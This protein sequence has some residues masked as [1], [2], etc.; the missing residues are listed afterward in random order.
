MAKPKNPKDPVW[1]KGQ[2]IIVD[3][4]SRDLDQKQKRDAV[5]KIPG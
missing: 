4:K 1:N 5:R 3:D 2:N